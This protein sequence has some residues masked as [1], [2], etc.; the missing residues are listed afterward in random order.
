MAF[1]AA[2]TQRKAWRA[3]VQLLPRR[4]AS[5]HGFALL[6]ELQPKQSFFAGGTALASLERRQIASSSCTIDCG[7]L[8]YS[9]GCGVQR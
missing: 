8:L 3:S 1:A 9:V 6:R 7:Q 5:T 4:L 2:A